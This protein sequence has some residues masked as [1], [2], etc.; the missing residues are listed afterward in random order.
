ML[1][2]PSR[3]ARSSFRRRLYGLDAELYDLAAI[4]VGCTARQVYPQVGAGI[5]IRTPEAADDPY[6]IVKV[7]APLLRLDFAT[8]PKRLYNP[9][10]RHRIEPCL[11][12]PA[13]I[14]AFYGP[15]RGCISIRGKRGDKLPLPSSVS[16]RPWRS[17]QQDGGH[18]RSGSAKI[19]GR[20]HR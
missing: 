5:C 13:S 16:L 10:P 19:G 3:C 14:D 1:P 9:I 6:Y 18:S 11:N 20:R 12:S 17:V 15:A 8:R 7:S 4:G 2:M